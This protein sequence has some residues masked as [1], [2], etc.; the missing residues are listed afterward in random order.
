M[1]RKELLDLLNETR[2]YTVTCFNLPDT[3]LSKTYA[4]GKWNVRQILH[5]LTDTEYLFLGRLK[6]IIAEP[7][8]VIWS[9]N[10]DDWN[11]AFNYLNAPLT[12][13]K[14]LY[15][16]CRKMNY[17]LIDTYYDEYLQKEF[18]HNQSG[19]RTL[20]MEFEKVALHNQSH[21]EQIKIARTL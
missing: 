11:E 12:N 20:K 18:V 3:D 14:E 10:Q 13:K 6:K 1:T 15:Q 16:L 8:Q 21:N 9:F 17:Q 5:H 7:Q 4:R 19:L 2:K